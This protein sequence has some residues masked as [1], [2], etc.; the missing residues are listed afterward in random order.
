RHGAFRLAV[1]GVLCPN[2]I[3]VSRDGG[4]VYVTGSM[5]GMLHVYDRDPSSGALTPREEAFINTGGDNIEIDP[6]GN[7][8]IAAHPKLFDLT[9]HLSDPTLASPSQVIRL[10][11]K[12]GGGY[13]I[14]E[15][16]LNVGDEM[17]G[18]SAA[19][20]R[21]RRLLIGQIMGNGFLDC[22]MDG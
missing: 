20:V 16:Y 10:S 13:E 2:G 19:A 3:N 1:E 9:A 21:G 17:S 7:L 22:L 11:P 12:P 18:S 8:W 5:T 4:V 15:V 14:T 6:A